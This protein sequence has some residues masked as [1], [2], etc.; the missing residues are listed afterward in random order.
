M[1]LSERVL[2]SFRDISQQSL[3]FVKEWRLGR[4]EILIKTNVNGRSDIVTDLDHRIEQNAKV[5]LSKRFPS[6]GFVGE[7]SFDGWFGVFDHDYFVID[8][9]DGTRPFVDG[10]RD[11]GISICAVMNGIPTV[12]LLHIPDKNLLI[13]GT[14]GCGIKINGRK[15]RKIATSGSA[16]LK[17]GI[18]PRQVDIAT[19]TLIDPTITSFGMSALIPKVAA[20][21]SGEI[22]AAVYY[23]EAGKSASIWDYAAAN[24]LINEGGGEMRSLDGQSL[25]YC[26]E[27]VV[28]RKGWVAANSP[29]VYGR[30][31]SLVGFG[32]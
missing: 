20:V 9:I 5:I 15:V 23:P 32:L 7:E 30:I 10:G 2:A 8:P 11:W 29:V 28:H 26:G 17:I 6:F 14:A 24:F 19:R 4:R 3:D 25:P 18:S 22:D 1:N 16:D 31:R 12:A 27:G 13:T 21:I